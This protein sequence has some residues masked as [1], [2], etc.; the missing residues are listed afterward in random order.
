M[1]IRLALIF[2][3]ILLCISPAYGLTIE[4]YSEIQQEPSSEDTIQLEIY[5]SGLYDGL[6]WFNELHKDFHS[7]PYRS[8]LFF[9]L[10]DNLHLNPK[11][12]SDILDH[13]VTNQALSTTDWSWT[14]F[15]IEFVLLE[16]LVKIFPCA[17]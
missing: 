7:G 16:Q 2:A 12:L 17:E 4:E 3:T 15:S 14:N 13:Y 11:N 1:R 5:L 6:K 8:A 10:P 9:C